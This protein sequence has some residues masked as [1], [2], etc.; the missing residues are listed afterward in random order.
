MAADNDTMTLRYGDSLENV[1]IPEHVKA[2]AR[3]YLE[4]TGN[5]DLAG[6]LGLDG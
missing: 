5:A 6:M 3:T 2:E 1:H 4:R